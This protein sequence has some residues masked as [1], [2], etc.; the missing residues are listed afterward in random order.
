MYARIIAENA[1]G[2]STESE[3]G[4]GEK[5]LT[6]PDAPLNLIENVSARTATSVSLSWSTGVNNGGSSVIDFTITYD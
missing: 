4:S 5:I 1:Y 3:P 2:N 6:R